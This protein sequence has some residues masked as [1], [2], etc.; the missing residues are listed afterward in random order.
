MSSCVLPDSGFC[1]TEVIGFSHSDLSRRTVSRNFNPPLQKPRGRHAKNPIPD[2]N[3]PHACNTCGKRYVLKKSLWRHVHMECNVEP[4]FSCPLCGR[5]FRQKI[6]LMTHLSSQVCGKWNNT[7]IVSL[8]WCI[9]SDLRWLFCIVH[10]SNTHYQK[11][12]SLESIT[13]CHLETKPCSGKFW[14]HSFKIIK[15]VISKGL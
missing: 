12:I 15:N 1:S 9:K 13:Y 3:R 6:H 11:T 14:K 4:K 10:Y 2:S 8:I 7:W 5:K